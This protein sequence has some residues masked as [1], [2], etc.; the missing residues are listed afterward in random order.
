M[1]A[2]DDAE[3]AQRAA[4]EIDEDD[5][6]MNLL[7][8]LSRCAT[9]TGP[10]GTIVLCIGQERLDQLR[11]YVQKHRPERWVLQGGKRYRGGKCID[12]P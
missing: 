5:E 1:S 4:P 6:S 3:A 2:Q 9:M 12:K 10:A 7:E 8:D 11:A